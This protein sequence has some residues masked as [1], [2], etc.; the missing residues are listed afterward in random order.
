MNWQPIETAPRDG[1]A[2]LVY[3]GGVCEREMVVV[4]Y[5]DTS[6]EGPFGKFCWKEL[7]GQGGWAEKCVTHWVPLPD[8]PKVLEPTEENI[9]NLLLSVTPFPNR[10]GRF[11]MA[12]ILL[13]TFDIRAR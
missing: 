5:E 8:P 12:R 2:I 3:C 13:E 4:R 10:A 11:E 6:S 9:A 1:T 7:S